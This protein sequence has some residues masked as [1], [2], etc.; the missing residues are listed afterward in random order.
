MG[1]LSGV[2]GAG[3]FSAGKPNGP[4]YEIEVNKGSVTVGRFEDVANRRFA[5]GYR[6][7]QVYEQEGN[8][9]VIW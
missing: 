3:G 1:L 4:H 8:T 9:I 5:N 6:L 7:H 2:T